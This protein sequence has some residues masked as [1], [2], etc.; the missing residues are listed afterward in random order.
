MPWWLRG[1]DHIVMRNQFITGGVL[2]VAAALTV[3]IGEAFDLDLVHVTVLGLAIGA[4]AVLVDDSTLATRMVGLAVGTVVAWV[5]FGLRAG[6]LPDTDGGRAVAFAATFAVV[7]VVAGVSAGR[8]SLWSQLL[9]VVAM[10]GAYEYTFAANPPLFTTE[11]LTAVTSVLL[12]V[13]VGLVVTTATSARTAPR[14]VA[15]EDLQREN[16]R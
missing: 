2:A 13:M 7:A 15:T 6:F 14:H 4:I 5:C 9:G 12:T 3:L 8:V 10:T 11:S 1:V 16:A